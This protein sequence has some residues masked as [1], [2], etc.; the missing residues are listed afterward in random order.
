MTMWDNLPINEKQYYKKLITS[1]ASLSEAFNQKIESE[2]DSK[3]IDSVHTKVAP[4]V[5]SK[6]QETVFQ[7]SFSAVGE[8]VKNTSFDASVIVD[9]NHKYLVGLKSFGI[10]SGAQKIA[11][12]KSQQTSL[13]WRAIFNE[14]TNN[15]IN[16]TKVEI[17]KINEPLYKKLAI[18]ISRLRNERI[19]SSKA[20]LKGFDASEVG[21]EAVYHYLL[22]SASGQNPQIF[23]GETPYYSI[24]IENIII[25]G[26]TTKNKPTNFKFHDGKHE[27][28]YAEADSQLFMKFDKAK[29]EEWDIKYIDNPFKFFA[30]MGQ[31]YQ[32]IEEREND[33]ALTIDSSVSWLINV[34]E[35][36]G[37]NSFNGASKVG[38]KQRKKSIEKI[39]NKYKMIENISWIVETL[40]HVLLDSNAWRTS[41]QKR[42][43]NKIKIDFMKKI[44]KLSIPELYN[45]CQKL[46]YRPADEIYIPIPDSKNFHDSHIDFFGTGYG[47]LKQNEKGA[48]KYVRSKEELKF[49]LEFLPSGNKLEAYL[50]DQ[51]N[52]KAIQS[53][54]KQTI[55]GHWILRE[56]F[57][58][59]PFEVLTYNRLAELEINAIRLTKFKDA[60]NH[61]GLEFIWIDKD[62]LPSDFWGKNEKK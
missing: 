23:V 13:G 15:S 8:D 32:E 2:D 27:Y 18:E 62:K 16:K 4:I 1:F 38:K 37:F 17:D 59:K 52:G 28:I 55:L 6:F 29:L 5:N 42:E 19:E 57:R 45:E 60:D 25:D 56:L 12:F 14:I 10:N 3:S 36:S 22:P 44:E 26:C 35:N 30:E 51:D 48:W 49:T 43:R 24:D 34:E 7:H 20:N 40:N 50:P 47:E 46:L 58:L 33:V 39:Q 21:V 54:N 41:E 61:I 9:E 11:Q 53:V 31:E